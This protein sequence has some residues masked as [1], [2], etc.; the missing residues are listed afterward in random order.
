MLNISRARLIIL[1]ISA[2]VCSVSISGELKRQ[3]DEEFER[4]EGALGHATVL[5]EVGVEVALGEEGDQAGLN[6]FLSLPSL[7]VVFL[8][9][10]IATCLSSVK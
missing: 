9:Y 6:G 10:S 8:A 1:R 5:V 7:S 4:V 3:V 2:N